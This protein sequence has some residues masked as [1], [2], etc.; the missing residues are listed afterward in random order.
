MDLAGPRLAVTRLPCSPSQAV[1]LAIIKD[2]F[3]RQHA[4]H[5]PFA[6]TCRSC[7]PDTTDTVPP[8]KHVV[9]SPKD[10]QAGGPV[11]EQGDSSPGAPGADVVPTTTPPIA[12]GT[13]DLPAGPFAARPPGPPA[14]GPAGDPKPTTMTWTARCTSYASTN[15][16]LVASVA[17]SCQHAAF[18]IAE[19]G[20]LAAG[21]RC[22]RNGKGAVHLLLHVQRA[23]ASLSFAML[24]EFRNYR[25]S[26]LD[27]CMDIS[28]SI[29]G[30]GPEAQCRTIH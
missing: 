9:L 11:R 3:E 5:A 23:S 14:G 1:Y 16:P 26:L 25:W 20:G 15:V 18:S 6:A 27:C 28:P 21:T 8:P 19:R 10:A 7:P 29:P 4:V 24:V 13:Y 30:L 17:V 12:E 22:P 2:K